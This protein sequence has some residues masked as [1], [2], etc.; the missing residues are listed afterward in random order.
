[1]NQVEYVSQILADQER[2]SRNARVMEPVNIEELI[3]KT[4]GT[5]S[6]ALSNGVDIILDESLGSTG[7]VM[8]SR[9]TLQQVVNNLLT[10]ALE[11]VAKPGG[12]PGGRIRIRSVREDLD[13]VPVSHLFFE[14]NGVG[15]EGTDLQRIFERGF[16]TKGRGTGLG[17]HWSANTINNMNGRIYAESD[18][19]GRGACFHLILPAASMEPAQ[20]T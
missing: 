17:L 8:S 18:G 6:P 2:F 7:T 1:M 9:A 3:V 12:P 15:I 11:A 4:T 10:N 20:S 14:D 19:R 5:L 16:S 13:G